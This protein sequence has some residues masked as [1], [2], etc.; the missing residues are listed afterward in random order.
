[1][2]AQISWALNNLTPHF[3]PEE[4][5]ETRPSFTGRLDYRVIKFWLKPPSF[6]QWLRIIT[7]HLSPSLRFISWHFNFHPPFL[8]VSFFITV[9][10]VSLLFIY[11][12]FRRPL[13]PL[14]LQNTS[15]QWSGCLT[16]A[17]PEEY[18]S[19]LLWRQNQTPFFYFPFLL[20]V[21][22][23]GCSWVAHGPALVWSE[24]PSLNSHKVRIW[25][26]FGF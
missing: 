22:A 24:N 9:P 7:K 19:M 13:P 21:L 26:S 23:C 6:L 11:C 16:A 20:L 5:M 12:L 3:P 4:R 18:Q 14:S 15:L 8:P 1:M 25:I 2:R 17:P 10:S